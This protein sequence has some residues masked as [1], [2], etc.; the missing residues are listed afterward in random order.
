MC[1]IFLS[2]AHALAGWGRPL[3]VV[4]RGSLFLC[5]D[6]FVAS[7]NR[8]IQIQNCGFIGYVAS[9]FLENYLAFEQGN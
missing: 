4:A 7:R 3:E 8:F 9:T 6:L 1:F 5:F 2:F